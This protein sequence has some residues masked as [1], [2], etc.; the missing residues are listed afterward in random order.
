MT[1]FESACALIREQINQ[2]AEHVQTDN[3][4][5]MGAYVG[6]FVLIA[7]MAMT[8]ALSCAWLGSTVGQVL[9]PVDNVLFDASMKKAAAWWLAMKTLE[10]ETGAPFH[11]TCI[12]LADVETV[13]LLDTATGL[14]SDGVE[15]GPEYAFLAERWREQIEVIHAD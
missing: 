13:T 14:S 1:A 10:A 3:K 4:A 7:S 8:R 15:F 9:S 6:N 5:T 11:D 12:M 2:N